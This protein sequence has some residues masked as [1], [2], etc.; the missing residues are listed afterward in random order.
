MTWRGRQERTALRADSLFLGSE[1]NQRLGRKFGNY[2][3]DVPDSRMASD[4]KQS[5]EE[6]EVTPEMIE[7]G[8]LE[9]SRFNPDYQSLEDAAERIYREMALVGRE[10]AGAGAGR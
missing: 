10:R 9:L 3:V 7:A 2:I 8:A 5:E 6:V 4:S 1:L